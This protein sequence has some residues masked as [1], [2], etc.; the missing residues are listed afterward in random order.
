MNR[1][2]LAMRPSF[3]E[4]PDFTVLPGKFT[5]ARNQHCFWQN[6]PRKPQRIPSTAVVEKRKDMNVVQR[7]PSWENG[8]TNI[9]LSE[10]VGP[11]GKDCLHF[12]PTQLDNVTPII[13]FKL[14][15]TATCRH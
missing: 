9:Q 5:S 8:T 14:F 13:C 10:F 15:L 7:E 11:G 12:M 4:I 6:S 3:L 2:Q 1:R